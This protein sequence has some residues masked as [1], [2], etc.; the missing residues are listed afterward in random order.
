LVHR[1][2][3]H[4]AAVQSTEIVKALGGLENDLVAGLYIAIELCVTRMHISTSVDNINY[5]Q[6]RIR[7]SAL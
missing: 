6:S 5:P 3:P 4:R 1:G 7:L 2:E